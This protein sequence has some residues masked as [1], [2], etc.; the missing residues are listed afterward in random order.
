MTPKPYP[1]AEKKAKMIYGLDC[2]TP[3]PCGRPCI[4]DAGKRHRFHTCV[5]A[6]CPKC[7]ADQRFGKAA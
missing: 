3:A 6:K 4:L 7:H 2:K 1:E 5:D